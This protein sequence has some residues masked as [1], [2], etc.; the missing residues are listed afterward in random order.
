M[1]IAI[2]GAPGCV[3]RNLIRKLLV[4]SQHRITASYRV[5][6]EIP[7]IMMGHDTLNWKQ[8][9]LFDKSSTE[10]FLSD[11][12]VLIYLV[13]S[14]DAKNFAKVDAQLANAAALGAK[15]AGIRK[16]IYLGGI[17]P[18]GQKLSPHLASRKKTGQ[19]LASY[20]VNV[21]EVRASILLATCSVS[22]LLV[23][24]L[25]KRLP[26][27]VTPR[28]IN[29]LCAPIA[30]EDAVNLI[31]ALITYNLNGHEIFEIGSNVVRYKELITLC[32]KYIR[33]YKNIVI[34]FPFLTLG[35]SSRW[36]QLLTGIPRNV[37]MALSEGLKNDTVPQYNRFREIIGR[38]PISVESILQNLVEEMREKR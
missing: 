6:E 25:A 11:S 38:E 20:D 7:D 21:A 31:E 32:G 3:G 1:N 9:N 26:I 36:L 2:L 28:W 19:I 5:K 12:E 35:M 13:H 29:S 18:E 22:F 15:N 33:G 23:Y 10:E 8:V 17:I 37:G 14:L 30:L 4:S 16:I 27:L 24:Y 34:P